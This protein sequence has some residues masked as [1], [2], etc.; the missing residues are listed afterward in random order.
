MS[1][2]RRVLVTG[3]G[4][5]IG[6]HVVRHLVG[7]GREVTAVVRPGDTLARLHDV[8][9]RVSVVPCDLADPSAL[10]PTLASWRPDAAIHLAWFSDAAK[11]L[12]GAENV[13]ALVA[14]LGLLDE[15]ILAGCPRVVM[16][17]TCAEYD[18]DAGYLRE[19]GPTRPQTLYAASKVALSLVG[20][21]IA[22]TAGVDL[23]W[24]RIFYVYGPHEDERRLVPALMGALARGQRF[25]ATAGEQVRDYLHVAD[26]AAALSALSEP[27][28]AGIVNVCSGV[29]VTMRQVMEMV[30]EIVGGGELI[31][32]GAVP[33]RG[34]DPPF[35]CGDNRR[36]RAQTGWRPHYPTLRA[37]LLQTAAWWA[38]RRDA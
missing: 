3:A 8:V 15:L 21:Q 24:A 1:P 14:S 5:F 7:S 33:Y 10:R 31:D 19:E 27:G 6:S 30:G 22:A 35:I 25:P 20:A 28:P 17:G 26:V 16:A 4:G 36:L 32:F 23:V 38:T 34:W 2:P 37:G 13:P 18:T 11:R 12:T 29:P 9:G